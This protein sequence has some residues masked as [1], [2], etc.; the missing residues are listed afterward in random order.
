[1]ALPIEFF[2]ENWLISPHKQ[3]HLNMTYSHFHDSYEIYIL[4]KGERS[5]VIENEMV[6]LK[7]RDVLLLKPNVVHCTTGGTYVRS[8]VTFSKER[9]NKYFNDEGIKAITSCFEHRVIRVCEKDFDMLLSF[10]EK[11]ADDEN[12]AFSLMQILYILKQNMSKRTLDLY[13][14]GSK[15]EDIVD[16]ITDDYKSIDNL[17]MIADKF[18]ISKYH[19]CDLFK[20]YTNTTIFKYI[21]VLKV[22]SSIELLL[23]TDLSLAEIAEKSGFNT[24][25]NYSKVFKS[26]IGVSP[27]EYRKLCADS[28][29]K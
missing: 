18:Y 25:A 1:M 4:E 23:R 22:H 24:L 28:K 7:P 17:D 16:Y 21:N 9:L 14:S 27:S 29:I 12:D 15:I 20:Q 26:V 6:H 19:L 8:L 2:V 11:L 13:E 5:Y 10:V 3:G